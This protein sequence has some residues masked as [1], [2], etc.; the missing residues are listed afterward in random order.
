MKSYEEIVENIEFEK[1]R[2][3]I[4]SEEDEMI[5]GIG[6]DI[7]SVVTAELGG[8]PSILCGLPVK[9]VR[10][11]HNKDTI[12]I[13]I[14]RKRLVTENPI[15]NLISLEFERQVKFVDRK[16]GQFAVTMFLDHVI[17]DSCSSE[18]SEALER[19]IR[20]VMANVK[21]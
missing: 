16:D 3:A 20:T 8:Y 4:L 18:V 17:Y 15:W 21:E 2:W 9:I 7:L 13:T 5:L 1:K 14:V 11:E 19:A 12:S 6:E 10:G